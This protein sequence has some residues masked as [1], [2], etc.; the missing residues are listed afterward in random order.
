MHSSNF[1]DCQKQILE[2]KLGEKAKSVGA[3]YK[4]TDKFKEA[5]LGCPELKTDSI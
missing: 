3:V 4:K 2:K 5:V 1:S